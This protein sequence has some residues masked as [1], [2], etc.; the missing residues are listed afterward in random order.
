[1][2][3]AFLDDRFGEVYGAQENVLLLATACA[4]HGH[5]VEVVTTRDGALAASA[6][7]RGLPTAVVAAPEALLKFERELLVGGVRHAM[8][9]VAA[10]VRYSARLHRHLRSA[11][12][13]LVVGSAVRPTLLLLFTGIRRRPRILLWAQNS[14]PLGILAVIAATLSW[15]V[16][17]I[18]AGAAATFP[19]WFRR[20]AARRFEPL[21]SGRDFTSL[22]GLT[23]PA[24]T[25]D[26]EIVSV[27]SITPRKGIDLLIDAMADADLPERTRL[28][29]V[30]GTTGPK[31][32]QHLAALR[33]QADARAVHAEFAGWH[34]DVRPFLARADIFVL[35]SYHEGLPGVLLEAMAAS[36]ACITTRAGGSG[37]LVERCGAGVAVDV[38]DVAALSRAIE[39][40]ARDEPGRAAMAATG[41]RSVRE[42]YSLEA[43]YRAFE[44]IA[45][46]R[47]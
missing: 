8:R 45:G 38:G 13:D 9:T 5:Q 41:A 10:L 6:R 44:R 14:T 18:S 31:S 19:A 28:T 4:D 26:L 16:G 20:P 42:G 1:M 29:V 21:P 17:L 36:R 39:R 32:E 7:S 33:A 37:E 11:G 22:D 47:R 46:R 2:K 23:R 25:H 43:S 15:R 12:I 3:I 30:G 34:D 35:S 27:C 24:P 40:L